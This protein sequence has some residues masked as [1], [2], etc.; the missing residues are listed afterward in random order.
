MTP[1]RFV[2]RLT[3]VALMALLWAPIGASASAGHHRG[4]SAGH[5]AIGLD[6]V[7]F[8]AQNCRS[9]ASDNAAKEL[10]RTGETT[11]E[12]IA[13]D[14]NGSYT[15]VT[16]A[17]LH[18]YEPLIAL[19]PKEARGTGGAYMVAASGTTDS[20]TVTARASDN[21]TFTISRGTSG[22]IVRTAR[23]CGRVQSW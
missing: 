17:T 10:A 12:T 1:R 9:A 23:V 4:R 18:A 5:T 3:A 21:N 19:T 20:Y 8:P 15:Q 14:N 6:I 13:T 7:G 11:A 16:L 2:P 22:N